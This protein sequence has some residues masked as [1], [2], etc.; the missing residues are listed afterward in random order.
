MDAEIEVEYKKNG[1]EL[2][3]S[4]KDGL[5]GQKTKYKI[6]TAGNSVYDI[7]FKVNGNTDRITARELA[8]GTF[9]LSYSNG[10]T[11]TV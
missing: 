11:E 3:F 2:E 10:F 9:E 6:T 1:A 5:A 8:D 4:V 7:Q